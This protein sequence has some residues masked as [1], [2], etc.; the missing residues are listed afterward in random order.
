LLEANKQGG[1]VMA[2]GWWLPPM[3]GQERSD[4]RPT[5]PIPFGTSRFSAEKK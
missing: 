2:W 3:A 4:S 1:G 5:L